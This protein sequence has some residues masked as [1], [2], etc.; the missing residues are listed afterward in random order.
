MKMNAKRLHMLPLAPSALA[1]YAVLIQLVHVILFHMR[2]WY[3]IVRFTH[4]SDVA[5]LITG[6]VTL[7]LLAQ[8]WD[9]LFS[10]QKHVRLVADWFF[11]IILVCLYAYHQNTRTFLDYS[12]I[13]ENVGLAFSRNSLRVIISSFDNASISMAIGILVVLATIELW[14]KF[15]LFPIG[16]SQKNAKIV[17]GLLIFIILSSFPL[18]TFDGLGYLIETARHYYGPSSFK[19]D[20]TEGSYPF[21]RE[22]IVAD[23]KVNDKGEKPHIFLIS[24]E[25]FNAGFVGAKNP[26][27]KDYLPVFNRLITQG[28]YAE[29]FYGNSVQ[30]CRGQFATFFSMIPGLRGKVFQ[31]FPKTRFRSVAQI[32]KENGYRTLYMQ[33]HKDIGYD[34]TESFLKNNGF[35]TVASIYPFLSRND[36]SQIWGWGPEDGVLYKRLFEYLDGKPQD[37]PFFV[38]IATIANHMRFDQA[39]PSKRIHF[40]NP[41]SAKEHYANSVALSDRDLP[42]FFDELAKRPRYKNAIVI[43][44]GDHSFPVVEHGF[45]HVELFYHERKFKTPFLMIGPGITP[46]RVTTASSQVD[47]APTILDAAGIRRVKNHFIGVSLLARHHEPDAVYLVQPYC[48]RYLSIVRGGMKYVWHARSQQELLFNLVL[49]PDEQHNIIDQRDDISLAPF[50]ERLKFVMLNQYLIEHDKVWPQND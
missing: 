25:S 9:L 14:K 32:L 7:F 15:I 45:E 3:D 50:R 28:L 38:A 29:N 46:R 5:G 11:I 19:P 40:K 35:E 49:D 13:A 42:I 27:G 43:I 1:V 47:I 41:G 23:K 10:F 22:T 21:V 33:G 44:T 39:P 17:S 37:K 30:T 4:L 8:I 12:V 36:L 24:I 16:H 20:Y 2:P 18:T 31:D 34:N 6:F 26:E 48:G